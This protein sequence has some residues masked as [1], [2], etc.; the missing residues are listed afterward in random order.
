MPRTDGPPPPRTTPWP[1]SDPAHQASPGRPSVVPRVSDAGRYNGAMKNRE[2]AAILREIADLLDI[3][4][5]NSFRIRS[6][7]MGADSVEGHVRDVSEM[8]G[9]GENLR[10]IE[11][12]GEGIASK[13]R[14]I[15][16]TGDCAYHKELLREIPGG[17]LELLDL[18]GLGPKGV[19]L[20]WKRLGVASAAELEV[21]IADG[22][23]RTLPGMKE[24]KEERIRKGLEVRRRKTG[25]FL[26]PVAAAA[27]AEF[28]RYLGDR[29]AQRV[30]AA[31]SYRRGRETVGDLDLIVVGGE[32]AALADAFVAHPDVKEVLAHGATK[33]SV[34]LK[35]GLQID[36]RQIEADSLGAA[37][38]YFTGGKAHN[39]SLRERALRQGL[40]LNEY[41][42][43]RLDTGAQVAGRTEEDVY[44]ALGL[45]W[46]PPEMREDRGEI[47]AA[48][49][50]PLPRLVE[51]DDI[52]GDL[53]AHTTES[54]GRDSL[55][56][57]VEAARGRGLDYLA[58]TDHSRAIPSKVNGSG[59]TEERC[60]A[61]LARIR[62]LQ[63]RLSGF[64]ILAGIEVDIL[65]DGRLDM[66]DEVLAKLDLVVAS[67]H[68]R[69]TMP[70]GE[71]TARVLRA[72]ENPHCH[73]WGHPLARMLL[74]RDP[75]E[76]DF[77]AVVAAAARHGV[78]LEINS[79]PHRLD[80][81]DGL[82]RDAREKGARFVVSTD[83]HS[84]QQFENLRFGIA[85]ARRGWLVPKDVLN[86]RDAAR[87]LALRRRPGHV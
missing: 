31:G 27:A 14:E 15:V 78:A 63:K 40:K 68:S 23:F 17:L 49:A 62:A 28:A 45:P 83:S 39:V 48:E 61:H 51:V 56:D 38:Q 43:F 81:P 47:G 16:E 13:I 87:F 20:V 3:R 32:P 59:M 2:V 4:G 66:A 24:K 67:L 85:Q 6:Y 21:A 76:V 80:L 74:R 44:A 65:P 41:G 19:S 57:M 86:T 60:L 9:R 72:F 11:G 34:V 12:V 8:V 69:F 75:V 18:P 26:L 84:V 55:S 7:R 37:L 1:G 22:R 46:I 30:E 73:V 82:I 5:D 77:P 53:H 71:M 42:V 64:R 79:Q 25:R 50:G 35:S 54:D 29:G 33:S 70:K 36:L 58:V 10:D 52:R